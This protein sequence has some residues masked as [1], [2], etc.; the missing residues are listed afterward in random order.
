[1]LSVARNAR[2]AATTTASRRRRN[3]AST[4][5]VEPCIKCAGEPVV[6]PSPATSAAAHTPTAED[7]LPYEDEGVMRSTFY[8]RPLPEH[9]VAF[10]SADGKKLFRRCLDAGHA[11]GYFHLAGNFASQSEPA[12]CGPSSLAMVLNALQ[13]DPR[14]RWK[15]A[16]RWYTDELLEGCL[17][18]SVIKRKGITFSQF[19]CMASGHCEVEA[20]R[21]EDHSYEEFM[22]DL[23]RVTSRTDNGEHMVVSYARATLGQTGDGHFSPV[24]SFCPTPTA[25]DPQGGAVLVLDVARFKYP[26]YFCHTRMLYEATKPL[27]RTTGK[28]RGWFLLRPRKNSPVYGC[29]SVCKDWA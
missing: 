15:G 16:W 29:A 27:D 7:R 22:A 10:D 5:S 24:G 4:I 6:P 20:K 9:L 25:K 23:R 19:A 14:R 21:P 2:L 11:E 18:L 3:S 28:S 13:I 1:M 8:R 17:P 26:S 12:Y